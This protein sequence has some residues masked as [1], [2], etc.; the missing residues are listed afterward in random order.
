MTPETIALISDAIKILGPASLTAFVAYK[1][2][3]VQMAIKLKEMDKSHEFEARKHLFNHYKERSR[4]L[5]K[6]YKELNRALGNLMGFT[7]G[8]SFGDKEN[9]EKFIQT[10][11]NTI[12]SFSTLAPIEL[13]IT[14][15]EMEKKRLHD[16]SEFA[17]LDS[18]I[19]KLKNIEQ[20]DNLSA[21]QKN[22]VSFLE[23]YAYLYYC[24]QLLLEK[25]SD[26]IFQKYL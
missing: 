17:E 15:K 14:K 4:Q 8:Y 21:L 10:I 11:S 5:L 9:A 12:R 18:Y 20:E 25:E 3:K 1:T 22:I 23:I 16:T 19:E 7:I 13:R 24:Q 26:K 2:A 6:N